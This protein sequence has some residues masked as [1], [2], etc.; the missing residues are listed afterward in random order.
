VP[1][2]TFNHFSLPRWLAS[3]GGWERAD[4]PERFARY[5][6]RA[7]AYLGDVV[8]WAC[9]INEP[10]I[11]AMMGYLGG[12][13]PPAVR[14]P[15][16]RRT[17]NAA[18]C[19]AHR[20]AAASL[21]AGPGEFPVGLTLSMTDYQAEPGGEERLERI[22]ASMEDVFLEATE[23][24]DF[25]GVQCYTRMRVG[26]AGA[27]APDPG[28]AVTQMGYEYWPHAVEATVRRAWDVT[29]GTPVMVTENGI[30]TAD[31]DERIR[32]VS[33]ALSSVHRC[34]ADGIDV[35][36]LLLLEPPRQLRVDPRLRAYVRTGGGGSCRLRTPP[37]AEHDVAGSGRPSQ[38]G[39]PAVCGRRPSGG[40]PVAPSDRAGQRARAQLL[41]RRRNGAPAWVPPR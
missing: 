13:F 22:R 37:Q 39:G 33:E 36:G 41:L 31:D 2:V 10:N 15:A 16:R 20:L 24:D 27:I 19:R 21:R 3:S 28:A 30:S 35:R 7:V 9:T 34:L 26:P 40:A 12:A 38:R 29:G 5:C 8:G 6:E 25:V 14:D 18:L 4:A 1:V 32:F 17:V 11:V 23:G